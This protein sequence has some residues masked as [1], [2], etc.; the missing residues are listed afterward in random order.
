MFSD[1]AP[2]KR[3]FI[4]LA[5][6]LGLIVLI[7]GVWW[8]RARAS[9]DLQVSDQGSINQQAMV[10]DGVVTD[11]ASGTAMTASTVSTGGVVGD[12]APP[13]DPQTLD[14]DGDGLPDAQ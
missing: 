8:L 7:G 9:A 5:L 2:S 4:G 13:V 11:A 6:T 12:T 3:I 1:S 10:S 14:S